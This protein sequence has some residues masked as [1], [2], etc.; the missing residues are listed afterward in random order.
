M[1]DLQSF[2]EQNVGKRFGDKYLFDSMLLN[3]RFCRQTQPELVEV[4]LRLPWIS[5][6]DCL[7]SREVQSNI[8]FYNWL[9]ES[10]FPLAEKRI[11]RKSVWH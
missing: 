1:I 11:S 9:I 4:S 10:F 8:D 6:A 3:T 5:F 7:D 2:I